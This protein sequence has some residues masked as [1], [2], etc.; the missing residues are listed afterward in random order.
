MFPDLK[1]IRLIKMND[2][3]FACKLNLIILGFF[4][5]MLSIF[6]IVRYG[7]DSHK[8]KEMHIY[9]SILFI[10]GLVFT[11]IGCFTIEKKYEMYEEI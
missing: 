3:N 11:M 9:T 6:L 4:L 1:L 10:S 7:G 5:F 2:Y 8:N